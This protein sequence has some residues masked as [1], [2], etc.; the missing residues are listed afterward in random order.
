MERPR[1]I[2]VVSGGSSDI[3]SPRYSQ[4]H[5][6]LAAAGHQSAVASVN[7]HQGDFLHDQTKHTRLSSTHRC[8][9]CSDAHP[10]DRAQ[11]SALNCGG[12]TVRRGSRRYH[13]RRLRQDT[14]GGLVRALHQGD[15]N[16][17]QHRYRHR[18][19]AAGTRP[20]H[21]ERRSGHVGHHQQRRHHRRVTTKSSFHPRPF[22]LMRAVQ[23]AQR[24]D[25]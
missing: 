22:G 19:R 24:L 15:R 12:R 11:P 1:G 3:S 2:A 21:G 18:F 8:T 10:A 14:E 23:G 9:H 17:G 5:Q 25:R 7:G 4:G 13:G 6:Q 16:Q 20:G